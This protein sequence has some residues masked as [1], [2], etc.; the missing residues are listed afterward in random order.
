MREGVGKLGQ[1]L[2]MGI[3]RIGIKDFL[4]WEQEGRSRDLFLWNK[5][6]HTLL[7]C[8]LPGLCFPV[9]LPGALTNL[10]FYSLAFYCWPSPCHSVKTEGPG[11]HLFPSCSLCPSSYATK[12]MALGDSQIIGEL[13]LMER[14]K[15]KPPPSCTP[16][17]YSQNLHTLKN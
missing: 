7:M 6:P 10:Q 12:R 4:V 11:C 9:A 5:Q 13:K 1:G 14:G 16:L 3:K 8:P 15:I 2:Q 17:S